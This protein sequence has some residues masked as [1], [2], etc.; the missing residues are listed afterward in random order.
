MYPPIH[1][2]PQITY[3]FDRLDMLWDRYPQFHEMSTFATLEE[4]LEDHESY[5]KDFDELREEYESG[6]YDR[7]L[8]QLSWSDLPYRRATKE[9]IEKAGSI[10]TNPYVEAFIDQF[11][12]IDT[13][14]K[15]CFLFPESYISQFFVIMEVCKEAESF[16]PVRNL[17]PDEEKIHYLA[18]F[19]KANI[20]AVLLMY[21]LLYTNSSQDLYGGY[22]LYDYSLPWYQNHLWTCGTVLRSP[23]LPDKLAKFQGNLPFYHNPAKT[24]YVRRNIDHIK[25]CGYITSELEFFLDLTR[26]IMPLFQWWYT[27]LALYEEKDGLR[28]NWRLRRTRIRTELTADGTIRPKWKHEL[29]LFQAIR[30]RHPDTLYQY[31]PDWL[32]R[33]SLDLYIPSL[34]TAIEYQGIQHYMPIDFFGGEDALAARQELDRQKRQLCEANGVRLIEWP[35]SCEPTDKNVREAL[36]SDNALAPRN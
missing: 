13:D 8:V 34:K 32:G 24:V 21:H 6:G 14:R 17:F 3:S 19:D 4:L 9:F 31:R 25:E 12:H 1:K 7:F 10:R 36:A 26:V 16:Y 28:T 20:D 22:S 30:K 11:A 2:K 27:D 33:Q 15:A 18:I 5:R 23:Y 35:Y 29:S